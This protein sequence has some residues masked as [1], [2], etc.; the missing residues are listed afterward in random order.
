MTTQEWNIKTRSGV[1][2]VTS[3]AFVEGE[4]V[5]SMLLLGGEGYERRDFSE[6]GWAQKPAE[7]IPLSSWKSFFKPI[8]PQPTGPLKQSDAQGLLRLLIQENEPHTLN[9]RSVLALM[10]ERKKQLRVVDRQE[11]EG[12]RVVIYEH[13]ESGE[14]W[15]IQD[16]QLRLD[17][18]E[19][20]QAEVAQLLKTRLG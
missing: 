3:R 13:L 7:W 5:H 6:E 9:A 1:C 10:L 20:V 19:P 17:Q 14:T 11:N 12:E 18:L 16:P 4:L 2:A 15:I 8:P